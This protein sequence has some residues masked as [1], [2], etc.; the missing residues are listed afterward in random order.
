MFERIN[1]PIDLEINWVINAYDSQSNSVSSPAHAPGMIGVCH[2]VIVEVGGVV[3]KQYI[4]VVEY[5]NADL[6]LGRPYE[7]DTRLVSENLESGDFL[8]IVRSLDGISEAWFVTSRVE[9]ERNH[10]DV[11]SEQEI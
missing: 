10:Q 2:D 8:I 7:H 9:H 1:S 4:F 3:V 6:I 5:S 11:R